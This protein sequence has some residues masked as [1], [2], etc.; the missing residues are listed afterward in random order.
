MSIKSP[1]FS[2][3]DLL[4]TSAA[5]GTFGLILFGTPNYAQDSYVYDLRRK[6]EGQ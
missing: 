6:G 2:Q 1:S 3:R 5:A 4:A